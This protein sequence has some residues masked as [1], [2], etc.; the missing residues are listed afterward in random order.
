MQ[1]QPRS[2][3]FLASWITPLNPRLQAAT[4][5]APATLQVDRQ[6]GGFAVQ[7]SAPQI[8]RQPPWS[9][10][11]NSVHLSQQSEHSACEGIQRLHW[12]LLQINCP[13]GGNFTARSPLPLWP[14]PSKHLL[15]KI[16]WAGVDPHLIQDSHVDK[17][18]AASN[19]N[20]KFWR[21][22]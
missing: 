20:V 3:T 17:D 13:M 11:T 6:A 5:D 8:L 18:T 19:T 7:T 14:C 22:L 9:E 21:W 4:V 1:R 15:H 2:V 12:N 16:N 10:S